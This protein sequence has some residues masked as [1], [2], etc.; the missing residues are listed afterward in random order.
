MKGINVTKVLVFTEPLQS[1]FNLYFSLSK[2]YYVF[3][4]DC[5]PD[6]KLD[7][8]PINPKWNISNTSQ[9]VSSI[10]NYKPLP[11]KNYKKKFLNVS[12]LNLCFVNWFI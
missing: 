9:R 3:P 2:Q 5:G 12:S 8:I 10:S 11:T 6:A 1:S 7:K 4:N